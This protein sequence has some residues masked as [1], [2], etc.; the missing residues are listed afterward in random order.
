[1]GFYI[2]DAEGFELACGIAGRDIADTARAYANRLRDR[3]YYGPEGFAPEDEFE[4][5]TAVDPK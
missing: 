4:T 3:V 1:M 2:V 5:R